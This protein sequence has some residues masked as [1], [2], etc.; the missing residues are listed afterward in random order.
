MAVVTVRP[1]RLTY[2]V[3]LSVCALIVAGWTGLILVALA[4]LDVK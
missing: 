1:A 4:S 3:L 2:I